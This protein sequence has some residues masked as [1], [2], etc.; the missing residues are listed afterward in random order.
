MLVFKSDLKDKT[1][2]AAMSSSGR[3]VQS[4]GARNAKALIWTLEQQEKI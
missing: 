4:V 1:E 3:S 2:F